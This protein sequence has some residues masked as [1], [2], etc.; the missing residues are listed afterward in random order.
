MEAPD[1]GS[2]D[3]GG[4]ALPVAGPSWREVALLPQSLGLLEEL[5]VRENVTLPLRLDPVA[6]AADVD[7]LL[8][9]L[10]LDLLADRFPHEISLGEQQRTALARAAVVRPRL[11]LAHEPISHQ[12]RAWAER[13]IEVIG[14]L[15]AAGT[16]CVLATHDELA[17]AVA[18]RVLE[19][20]DGQ[21]RLTVRPA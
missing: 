18:G 6:P 11:L 8:V 14:E 17:T 5:T 9:G 21:L 20:R 2:V 4:V 15:A 19:L 1:A 16:A 3:L 10:G 7:G 12:N 13:T